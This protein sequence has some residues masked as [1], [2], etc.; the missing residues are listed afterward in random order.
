[1]EYLGAAARFCDIEY[2]DDGYLRVTVTPKV[3]EYARMSLVDETIY[4]SAYWP[5]VIVV[6]YINP[7]LDNCDPKQKSGNYKAEE[8]AINNGRD[9]ACTRHSR[10]EK[11]VAESK[12]VT[13]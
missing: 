3:S 6:M 9:I 10:K 7:A 4:K 2:Q 5:L 1:V 11:M 12:S 13:F 8:D